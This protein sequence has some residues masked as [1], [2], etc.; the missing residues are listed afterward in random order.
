MKGRLRAV[1]L[2]L[3]PT[4]RPSALPDSDFATWTR[5]GRQHRCAVA[6]GY[7]QRRLADELRRGLIRPL[8]RLDGNLA[9][10]M[11]LGARIYFLSDHEGP[12]NL[13]SCTP[14]GRSL[15]RHTHH[16]DFYVRFP[17]TDGKRIVYHAGADLFVYDLVTGSTTRIDVRRGQPFTDDVVGHYVYRVGWSP[18]G[19]EIAFASTIT[20]TWEIYRQ[21][22]A[23]GK[24]H[25]VTFAEADARYP[26]YRPATAGP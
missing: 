17:S 16:D 14:T 4:L 1:F 13:Y 9:A 21:R 15:K 22:L 23:D 12:G 20:G 11:W 25:R 10:P 18:D 3:L 6:V 26:D 5:A 7:D 2:F 8:I 24:A 19:S